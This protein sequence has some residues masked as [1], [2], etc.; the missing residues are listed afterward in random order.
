MLQA[1]MK[2]PPTRFQYDISAKRCRGKVNP[3]NHSKV[4]H[5]KTVLQSDRSRTF[6]IK[7]PCRPLSSVALGGKSSV[8][9][10][11]APS[12]WLEFKGVAKLLAPK[13]YQ[14]KP[15]E[16]HL[17]CL[18]EHRAFCQEEVKLLTAAI[19]LAQTDGLPLRHQRLVGL[20]QSRLAF[21][22]QAKACHGA[23]CPISWISNEVLAEIFA[24][25]LPPDHRFSCALAPLL[26]LRICRLWRS[27]AISTCSFWSRLAFWTPPSGIDLTCY[28]LRFLSGWLARSGKS[29]LD[30]FLLQG[31]AYN[32][33]RFV[34]EVVLLG[35]YAQ[36]RHLDIH[37]TSESA[38]SLINFIILP[39]GSLSSLKSLVLEGLD[40]AYFAAE[41]AG[42]T[43]TAFQNSPLL[44]KLTTNVLD[45]AFRLNPNASY[46]DFDHIF[47][48]WAQLTHLM[49]TDFI[50]VDA[51]V[52]TISECTGLEFLRV[53]LDLGNADVFIN[54]DQTRPDKPVAL[55]SLAELY[56][57][58]SGGTCIPSAMNALA[59]P[60]LRSLHFRRS[61]SDEFASLDLFSWRNSS[62]FLLQLQGL[63]YLSLVGRVGATEE[64][65]LLLQNTPH[66]TDL[67]LDISTEYQFLIPALFPPS[68]GPDSPSVLLAGPLH[69]L[70]RLAFRL[71]KSDFPFPSR[72]IR[73]AVDSL[74]PNC[75][76]TALTIV[77]HRACHRQLKEICSQFSFT[78]L[79]TVIGTPAGPIGRS[80]RLHTDG[81]LIDCEGTSR[82]YA[83]IDPLTTLVNVI[84]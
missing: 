8:S 47:L 70:M 77:A 32:H 24:Y 74:W 53:S 21:R 1:K 71:T 49:V 30:I 64:V 19:S 59:F 31:L 23:I 72:C 15:S 17:R 28:P 33:M 42:P 67:R 38:P 40:G 5:A 29:P 60:A 45:F 18:R 2:C 4:H 63:Q 41:N 52:V 48:P 75:P 51:F 78:P 14:M 58:I 68:S 54:I 3:Y 36:C 6:S 44:R 43:M 37:L 16:Q 80:A 26:L 73:D 56:I 35:H 12:D 83:M 61:E 22:Q 10:M 84:V 46:A 82:L 34:V 39:P 7:T 50:A 25:C 69:A 20:H 9:S 13:R 55:P 66:V 81:R 76:L 57:S 62:H 65:F 11:P 79:Q 27:I